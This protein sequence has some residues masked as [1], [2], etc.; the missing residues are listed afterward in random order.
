MTTVFCHVCGK[1]IEKGKLV[2]GHTLCDR[3]FTSCEAAAKKLH[4]NE[5]ALPV[6]VERLFQGSFINKIYAGN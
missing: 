4:G 1:D 6:V 3:C 5:M 2:A